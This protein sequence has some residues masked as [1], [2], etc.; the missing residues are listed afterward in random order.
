VNRK[1][2]ATDCSAMHKNKCY[3][4]YGYIR[5]KEKKKQ[6]QKQAIYVVAVLY[7][8]KK[9]RFTARRLQMIQSSCSSE[10]CHTIATQTIG[11]K[12]NN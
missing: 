6:K 8:E 3:T 1:K 5:H 7:Q 12:R 2:Y 9:T 11:T 4:L 10:Q